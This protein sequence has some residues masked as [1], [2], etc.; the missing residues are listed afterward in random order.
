MDEPNT[1]SSLQSSTFDI[2][3][4]ALAVAAD[5]YIS[6]TLSVLQGGNN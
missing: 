6:Y 1:K 4:K 3:E 2:D 5:L